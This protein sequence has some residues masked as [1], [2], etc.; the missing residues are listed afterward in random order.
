[1]YLYIP[2]FASSEVFSK[3]WQMDSASNVQRTIDGGYIISGSSDHHKLGSL[4]LYLLKTDASGEID[5][6]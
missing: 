3:A 6:Q 4:T 1:M 5:D 2:V